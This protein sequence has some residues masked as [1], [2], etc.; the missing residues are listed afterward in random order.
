VQDAAKSV[1]KH[2]KEEP[3]M[4]DARP[5]AI[6]D[7]H[8]TWSQRLMA[9]L[10]GRGVP[11]ERIDPA[12]HGFLPADRSR[13]YGVV[14]NRVSPSSHTRGHGAALFYAH[15]FLAYVEALGIPVV[16][17][18]AAYRAE[19]SKAYQAL[20][21]ERLGLRY[22]RTAV[23]NDPGQA[24][25]A[26]HGFRFPVVVKPS[27]GGSGAGIVRFE[28]AEA[29][30]D[31]VAAGGA[32]LGPDGVALVQEFREPADGGIVR[33]EVLGGEY[34]YAIKIYRDGGAGFN[35]CPADIC[36]PD[37]PPPAP[38]QACPAEAPRLA[39]R[40]ERHEPGRPVVEAVL[41]LA[42]E[43]RIDVGG[44]EYLVDRHDGQ[45]YFYDVNATSNFVAD[46]PAVL[47]FDPTVRFADYILA[48]A[49]GAR[50]VSAAGLD[51][52]YAA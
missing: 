50:P 27:I 15:A 19:T 7:E 32:A 33:V 44:V 24:L 39:L 12:S 35:L 29:L 4:P 9:E 23:I 36:R 22:P 21:L 26:A 45:V 5:V 20:L 14:V 1:K 10:A 13:R 6:L 11:F 31:A 28:S 25:K 37:A 2:H 16:N 46:A 34:L 41:A 30:E 40:V 38:L 17:P 47:G 8:P 51:R 52:R 18:A 48:V 49:A 3:G 43:A 42:R